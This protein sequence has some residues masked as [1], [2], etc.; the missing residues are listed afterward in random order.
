MAG[1]DNITKEIL[2]EANDTASEILQAAEADAKERLNEAQ[3][4]CDAIAEAEAEQSEK[5]KAEYAERILA[6][7]DMRRRREILKAKQ[8]MIE[9]VIREAY[10][11]LETL[12]DADYF[13]MLEKLV[14]GNV[15]SGDGEV[16]LSERDLKRLPAGFEA[17]CQTIAAEQGG[18]LTIS[19]DAASIANG[20]ILRYNGI[21][22][23]CTLSAIFA[24]KKEIL[25]DR[26]HSV[27]W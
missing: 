10:E 4:A 1:I 13:L 21:D 23:N 9:D 5:L 12:P 15:Q 18:S 25:Q 2:R 24:E 22:E 6:Q 3:K 16:L 8:E 11:K 27:L 19:K 26:V 20:L 14:R 7:A 17:T